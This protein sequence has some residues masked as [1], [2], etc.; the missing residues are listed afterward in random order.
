MFN[1]AKRH[2]GR[3]PASC[4]PGSI[5]KIAYGHGRQSSRQVSARSLNR[6]SDDEQILKSPVAARE[7]VRMGVPSKGRMADDTLELLNSCQLKCVK[8]NP[9]Q[10]FGQIPQFPD[11]E[12]W[13]QRASDV[14]RKLRTGDLDIGIVGMD[15]FAEF[16]A[17]D[18]D[19]VVIHDALGFGHCKLALG[20]PIKGKFANIST[21]EDLK[22]MGWTDASPLRVVTGYT[23]IA[24][25]YALR[26]TS[27]RVCIAVLSPHT[28]ASMRWYGDLL[29]QQS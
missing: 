2:V 14:V 26:C 4:T 13:F 12:V 21:I 23:N 5:R 29:I 18:E 7:S 9:R 19:L 11:M 1:C 28:T 27:A 3:A 22:A 6:R 15:M 24:Y 17:E 10:Y 20:V 25:R 8:P 16:A